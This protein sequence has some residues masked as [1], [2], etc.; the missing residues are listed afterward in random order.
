M[1]FG[2]SKTIYILSMIQSITLTCVPLFLVCTG[3]LLSGRKI[4]KGHYFKI[5]YFIVEVI[6]I[7]SIG[8]LIY[9]FFTG[10]LSVR[11]SLV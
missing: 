8:T 4:T 7:Y 5:L 6:I 1:I 2:T 11:D 9:V 3:Y 10:N